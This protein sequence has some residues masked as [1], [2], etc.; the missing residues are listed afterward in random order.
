MNEKDIEDAR[1]VYAMITNIDD[2]I[3]LL[4]KKL[5]DL[6]IAENTVVIFMTDNGPQQ[7]RY[8]AGMRGLKS[9]VY[10]GG[11]RVPFWLS[12]PA[13]NAQN[14]EVDVN[15]ANIDVLPTL[16]DLCNIRV[17][18]NRKIDGIS[19]IP[20]I[21]GKKEEKDGRQLFYYWT[22]HSPELYNNIALQRGRFKLV[23]NTDLYSPANRF[24]LFDL[25][26]DPYE[27]KNIARDEPYRTEAMKKELDL[28][29][30][31]LAV[32][33]NLVERP[34]IEIGTLFENPVIL[35]RNDA[36]G[37]RGIWEQEEIF[38]FWRLA[39]DGGR[40][41]LKFKFIHPVPSGGEMMVETGSFIYQ[42]KN[43]LVETNLIEMKNIWF[44]SV[45]CDFV[46]FYLTGGRRIFPLWVEIE[47]V[48]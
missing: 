19:L 15:A 28:M 13:L 16:A 23:G 39:I 3:G 42:V 48:D 41:N 22:R 35:N 17:P 26:Q 36:D 38:G 5:Q 32:S 24:E 8:N 4:L 7:N 37:Q 46:P 20:Y 2:N 18:E 27:Q 21:N 1:R 40:Y 47:A 31:E 9:S 10:K 6:D 14:V 25:E 12:Y 45:K 11:V 34:R 30:M 43:D 44:P 29:F 33:E